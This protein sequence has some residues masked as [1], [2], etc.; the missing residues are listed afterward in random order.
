MS[1]ENISLTTV[2][3]S[4]SE[5][6]SDLSPIHQAV[7]MLKTMR[8]PTADKYAVSEHRVPG[9]HVVLTD[10]EANVEAVDFLFERKDVVGKKC[11]VLQNRND[12]RNT[13]GNCSIRFA[14]RTG[15]TVVTYL[16]NVDAYGHEF[17]NLISVVPK[18]HT[19][20]RGDK[21]VSG[22]Y[23]FQCP[24]PALMVKRFR[25]VHLSVKETFIPDIGEAVYYRVNDT[26]SR[27]S[28]VDVLFRTYVVRDSVSK[29]EYCGIEDVWP[30]DYIRSMRRSV[31]KYRH[32]KLPGKHEIEVL[33]N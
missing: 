4:L 12:P 13:E 8:L 21:V 31:N 9:M 20:L 33:A 14:M 15:T 18:F 30:M 32:R 11:S 24:M 3:H 10:T 2:S 26:Y 1:A 16:I 28:V 19:R 23:S 7:G 29:Y 27:G 17:L 6:S 5:A 22:F 25:P